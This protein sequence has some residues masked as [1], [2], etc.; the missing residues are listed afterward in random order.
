MKIW[1]AELSSNEDEC[2]KADVNRC[3]ALVRRHAENMAHMQNTVFR[4]LQRGQELYQVCVFLITAT[5]TN[6][7]L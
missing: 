6:L 5:E 7:G 3:E 1:T 2:K 4:V